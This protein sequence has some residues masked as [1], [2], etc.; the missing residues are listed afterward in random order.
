MSQ[1]QMH[2]VKSLDG[3]RGLAAF[4]VVLFHM[5]AFFGTAFSPNG[6][7]THATLAWQIYRRVFDGNF[8]VA[9]FFVLSG[10]VLILKYAKLGLSIDLH[11]GFLKRY[12]RL[13]PVVLAST[14]LAVLLQSTIGF[15][16]AEAAR[17]IGGHEWLAGNY[18]APLTWLG[19]FKCGIIGA[20]Q[21]YVQYNG[22]LWTI[23]LELLGSFILFGFVGLFFK[24]R[25]FVIYSLAASLFMML[26]FGN[27]GAYLSLFLMGAVL[28][29]HHNFRLSTAWL[30]PAAFLASQNQWTPDVIY[31]RAHIHINV[32]FDILCHAVA[33]ILLVG[34]VL[35]S[36][37]IQNILS[38]AVIM[39]L[40]RISFS[41]YAVHLPIMMSLGALS[42]VYWDGRTGAVAAIVITI[43]VSIVVAY[44]F[45]ET[46]DK[47]SQKLANMVSERLVESGRL[48][49][50][51]E[52]ME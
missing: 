46:F 44:I 49:D 39:F 2:H 52:K 30:I 9:I 21:G 41:L 32:D 34:I 22:P 4:V 20:Y 8:S 36:K 15:H 35:N 13:T 37:C 47:W 45:T 29:K 25:L 18:P 17:M 42:M 26:L 14:V 33:A 10:Y 43:F 11:A 3:L 40:G 27:N 7:Y 5:D 23:R 19:S 16:N 51:L 48:A 38:N 6:Q 1:N 24:D 12:F 50:H 28:C 31:A